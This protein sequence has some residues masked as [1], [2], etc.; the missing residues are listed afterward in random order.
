MAIK[1]LS[2][3][4]RLPRLGKIRLGERAVNEAGIEY[5]R[6][7]EHFVV[8]DEVQ[9]VYGTGPT[10]LEIMF[11][12]EDE[13]VFAS[14]FYRS[15]S[16]TRGLVCKGDGDRAAR[17]IDVATKRGEP[18]TGELTGDIA[19]P[20]AE[21]VE[22]LDDIPCPGQACPYYQGKECSESMILQFLLPTVPGVGVWQLDTKSVNGMINVNSC[23]ALLRQMFGRVS[24]IPLILSLEP[25][26]V[27]PE[28]RKK[29][30]H[31]LQ[32]RSRETMANMLAA[33]PRVVTFIPPLSA[34]EMKSVEL[35]AP[36]DVG[37]AKWDA[38]RAWEA[39]ADR[40]AD[41]EP[42]ESEADRR[43]DAM[44]SRARS[45]EDAIQQPDEFPNI[46]A[47]LTRAMNPMSEG[48]GGYLNA[49]GV[50]KALGVK[51]LSDIMEV[52]GSLGAAWAWLAEVT[53]DQPTT[54]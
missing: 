24:G 16:R 43:W 7:T 13:A 2:D 47:L 15:Y 44:A 45:S 52:Y 5:P 10:S 36:A 22:W 54:H 31:V 42:A 49:A 29:T 23:L 30:V 39:L 40:P 53:S 21:Q 6:A 3:V 14:Q 32:L 34:E 18:L 33:G 4:V 35:P 48:G 26:E 37:P 1:G 8:P 9:E 12:L 46:G 38:E 11:P 41:V 25:M 28:G 17:L 27:H 50:Q 20:G 51:K 19:G